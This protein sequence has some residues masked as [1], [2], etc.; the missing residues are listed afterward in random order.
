M[1]WT[2]RF[3]PN[4]PLVLLLASVAL[5]AVAAFQ[6]QAAVRS[7]RRQAEE[8]LRDY[9]TFASW[10]FRQHLE[11]EMFR[12]A[13][14]VLQPINHGN[15]LHESPG[16]PDARDLAHYLQWDSAGCYCHR[17]PYPPSHFFAFVLGADTLMAVANVH[18][19]AT[20]GVVVD[21]M[22]ALERSELGRLPPVRHYSARER[23]WIVDT[24]SA[25]LRREFRLVHDYG[26]VFAE[27]DGERH[28]FAYRPMATSWGD[29][30]IYAFELSETMLAR[31]FDVIIDDTD[32]LPRALTRELGNRQILSVQ[33]RDRPGRVLYRSDTLTVPF[34]RQREERLPDSF[35]GLSVRAAIKPAVA[36]VLIIGGLPRSRLPMLFALLGVAA[37]LAVVAVQQLRR[38]AS[39]T[40]MRTEFV[41]GVSHELRTPLS[42]IRL[43]LD[44]LRLG[45]TATDRDRAWSL[46]HLDREATRLGHLV[47]NVLRFAS[48]GTTR[49]IPRESCDLATEIR[50][51]V[52]T[53]EPLARSRRAEFSFDF[54]DGVNAPIG[55]EAFRVALHN[56]L[57][58]AVKYGPPGQ[59]V[60]V[61]TRQEGAR[62]LVIVDDEGVGIPARDRSA[63]WEPFRRGGDDA[64]R[65][66]GGSGI[67]LAIVHDVMK[68]HGGD[69][70][71]DSAPG[72]GT[73]V[74]LRFPVITADAAPAPAERPRA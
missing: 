33:I 26:L 50:A 14:A 12:A 56:V 68:R 31:L 37:T 65:A 28:F 36:G 62:A 11:Q 67:G 52:T 24:L 61:R 3:R 60:T 35:A 69:A 22:V 21:T 41:A 53:F 54:D 15:S 27:H 46:D 4:L 58:N 48:I 73:R 39:L 55:R 1:K 19:D 47:E 57:D 43:Y 74:V 9:T 29:T 38:A 16:I 2:D 49:E 6:A 10:S 72:G 59:T 71:I 7:S 30:A 64:A 45:R 18:H 70:A 42:Q 13:A 66:V 44:T 51:T 40:R 32:L 5:L 8:A 34:A 20:Q 63:V 17:A 23:S 25:S